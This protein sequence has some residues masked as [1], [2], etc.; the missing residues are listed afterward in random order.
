[1]K[2]EPILIIIL[3]TVL[4]TSVSGVDIS[5]TP[6][7]SCMSED[8]FY[9]KY[10]VLQPSQ[11][12]IDSDHF[13]ELLN[14]KYIQGNPNLF[15]RKDQESELFM[16][17]YNE[18]YIS[19]EI[20]TEIT[21]KSNELISSFKLK[22]DPSSPELSPLKNSSIL[23]RQASSNRFERMQTPKKDKESI[24]LFLG[25]LNK[26]YHEKYGL[27]M[28][29]VRKDFNSNLMQV[30]QDDFLSLLSQQ[31]T[32]MEKQ[33]NFVS[34]YVANL[35][36]MNVVGLSKLFNFFLLHQNVDSASF[37]M[38]DFQKLLYQFITKNFKLPKVVDCVQFHHPNQ[39]QIGFVSRSVSS[40]DYFMNTK[41]VFQWYLS[42]IFMDIVET[43]SYMFRHDFYFIDLS[44]EDV[45]IISSPLGMNEKRYQGTLRD[46]TKINTFHHKG[47]VKHA[48]IRSICNLIK[49]FFQAVEKYHGISFEQVEISYSDCLKPKKEMEMD[50][51]CPVIIWGI[52]DSNPDL[53]TWFH[54]YLGL[55]DKK[56]TGEDV[57]VE[58]MNP[59]NDPNALLLGFKVFLIELIKMKDEMKNIKNGYG[60]GFFEDL[61]REGHRLIKKSQRSENSSELSD[62]MNCSDDSSEGNT[63]IDNE[64]G[65]N[66]QTIKESRPPVMIQIDE[67]YSES[68]VSIVK[69][70]ASESLNILPKDEISEQNVKNINS[71]GNLT[72][73]IM[74]PKLS[75]IKLEESPSPK[76]TISN[77]ETIKEKKA[78]VKIK[79]LSTK[80]KN[81][82]SFISEVKLDLF[83]KSNSPNHPLK[84]QKL[85]LENQIHSEDNSTPQ[86][87]K[88][89]FQENLPKIKTMTIADHQNNLRNAI[90]PIQ[91]VSLGHLRAKKNLVDLNLPRSP[92]QNFL[93]YSQ[94]FEH[95][96]N[97]TR[98]RTNSHRNGKEADK[99]INKLHSKNLQHLKNIHKQDRRI[100]NEILI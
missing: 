96:P 49:L 43:Y 37:E 10:S 30:E 32:I 23:K 42:K 16:K 50:E 59:I 87:R 63:E 1:M 53:K 26:Y 84:R 79:K 17:L 6:L 65:T 27:D 76:R 5:K 41:G 89:Q 36:T 71:S 29:D 95:V 25:K 99:L 15:L 90:R 22:Q 39:I 44:L 92:A 91:S 9:S 80:A 77:I 67:D 51:K 78:N 54:I 31:R 20:H 73:I 88:V 74:H 18:N 69:T 38:A 97:S 68:E 35:D 4:Y 52:F 48:Q 11:E 62:L 100:K 3:A 34:L 21:P 60:W 70:R 7:N 14:E 94:S 85:K 24:D 82:N 12:A 33:P 13:L 83:K 61:T 56:R 45:G 46:I 28:K 19:E 93:R 64:D 47:L 57:L 58:M 98:Q 75:P 2:A 72:R 66:N 55:I 8:E 40:L 81:V 86:M